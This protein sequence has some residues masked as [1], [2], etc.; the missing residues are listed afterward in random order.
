MKKLIVI[1]IVLM[2]SA[3]INKEKIEENLKELDKLHAD[4]CF[5]SAIAVLELHKLRFGKYPD[6]F[7]KL[8]FL[9]AFEKKEIEYV[10]YKKLPNGYELNLIIAKFKSEIN[11]NYPSEFWQGLGLR[12]SNLK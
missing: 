5:K 12:K 7:N 1:I 10:E 3:C 2:L 6:A 9:N 4:R 8:L 11:L